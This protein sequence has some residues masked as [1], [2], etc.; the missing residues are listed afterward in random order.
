MRVRLWGVQRWRCEGLSVSVDVPHTGSTSKTR[1]S[2]KRTR[3]AWDCAE[4]LEGYSSIV[5]YRL[6]RAA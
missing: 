1:R 4:K 5:S 3:A 6:K 2:N